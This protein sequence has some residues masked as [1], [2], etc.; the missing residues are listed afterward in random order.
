MSA[1][2]SAY[3]TAIL[4]F[5]VLLG[6]LV[7]YPRVLVATM[8]QA[9]ARRAAGEYGAALDGYRQAAGLAPTWSLPWQARGEV[10]LA[11]G[12]YA[13]AAVA[14]DQAERLGAGPGATL[15]L[16]ES[17]AGQGDW[18]G[19]LLAW[20]RAQTLAPDDPQVYLALARGSLAQGSF[21]Q[22]Q[23]YLE[24]ALSLEPSPGQSATAHALMG[25]LLAGDDPAAAAGHLQQAGD[26]DML[27][28]VHAV[29]AEAAPARRDLLL[30]AAFLQRDE[31]TLARR[32]LERSIDRDPASAEA[33]AYLAHALDRLGETVAAGRLLQ[34]ALALE[35]D[36]ALVYYFLGNHHLRLGRIAD[37][38][39]ALWEALQRDPDNA[40]FCVEMAKAFANQADYARAGEWYRAAVEAEPEDAGFRL[41][42][43]QFYV[44]HVYRMEEEGV[45]A[46]EE[47][48]ALAP[49]DARAQ[50]LLGWAYQLAG[51]P[52]EAEAA[53]RRALTLDPDLVSAHFHLGS[54]YIRATAADAST[55]AL[56]RQH[57]QRAADLD[58][59]GYYR[60]RAEMLLAGVP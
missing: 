20:L 53:L 31:L 24:A 59:N 8:Q 49:T 19:A 27:A 10:L 50:D 4:A 1:W 35:S 47:A 42:L 29:E 55:Q 23:G 36:S 39:A 45:A 9:T 60:A 16:G 13:E 26:A 12:R 43:A 21:Q 34:H 56:A 37:A 6:D 32:H 38:Q 33:H 15:A 18:A 30:G 44:D 7:P 48:A 28:V 3:K 57:L 14:L 2:H 41:L 22:A 52:A 5:F 40:A 51:R 17:L 54:L 58:T 11:Q 46:A 25:R